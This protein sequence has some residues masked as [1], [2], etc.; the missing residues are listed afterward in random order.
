MTT[1]RSAMRPLVVLVVTLAIL[2]GCTSGASS[3]RNAS[4]LSGDPTRLSALPRG[5][6]GTQLVPTYVGTEITPS[7]WVS[8][9]LTPTL[10]VPDARGAWTFTIDDL[11]DGKSGFGPRTYTEAGSTSRLPLGAGLQQ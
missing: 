10:V 11:S 1:M 8:T 3:P 2:A 7:T 4:G 5:A 6:G 9:S